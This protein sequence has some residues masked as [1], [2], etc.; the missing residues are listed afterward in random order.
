MRFTPADRDSLQGLLF[1]AT[2]QPSFELMKACLVWPDERPP[3][4]S[5][6]GYELLGDLWIVRG[7]IHKNVPADHWGLDPVYFQ[8]VWR[9]ARNDVPDWPGFKRLV[10]SAADSA[11]LAKCIGE[12]SANEDY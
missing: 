3:H 4:I 2:A 6:E 9:Q 10:L 5:K 8:E 1:D 7:Y 11:Y 12:T